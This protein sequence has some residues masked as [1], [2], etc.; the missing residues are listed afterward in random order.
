[1]RR[2]E[3]VISAGTLLEVSFEHARPD[4]PQALVLEVDR[5]RLA[6]DEQGEEAPSLRIWAD[7][8]ET[9]VLRLTGRFARVSLTAWHAWLEQDELDGEVVRRGERMLA[10]ER[11]SG[12]LLR[13][14]DGDL[15]ARIG[16]R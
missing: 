2:W 1:M 10:E 5:G 13:C 7:R 4:P 6:W 9:V 14:G 11:P 15:V 3:R 16:I 8:H 12:A